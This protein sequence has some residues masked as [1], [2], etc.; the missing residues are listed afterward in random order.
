MTFDVAIPVLPG[1]LQ[2]PFERAPT[3]NDFPAKPQ[4]R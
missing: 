3:D 4:D 1:V 2:H